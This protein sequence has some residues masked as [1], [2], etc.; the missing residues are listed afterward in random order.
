MPTWSNQTETEI[1]WQQ[2]SAV[3][4]DDGTGIAFGKDFRIKVN[5]AYPWRVNDSRPVQV[6]D[7]VEAP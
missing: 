7:D 5:D 2:L 1:G 6:V 3:T 4:E